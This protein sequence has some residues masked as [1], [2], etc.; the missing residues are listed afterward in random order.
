MKF[1][2]NEKIS[3]QIYL[4]ER[5]SSSLQG[6]IPSEFVI[7][8]KNS[9]HL[10]WAMCL[11]SPSFNE[12]CF[13]AEA[14][15]NLVLKRTLVINMDLFIWKII[16]CIYVLYLEVS[17]DIWTF[18]CNEIGLVQLKN[19][20][21]VCRCSPWPRCGVTVLHLLYALCHAQCASVSTSLA[22][23]SVP[24]GAASHVSSPKR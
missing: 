8:W 15:V 2:W 4:I 9:G 12:K 14:V 5:L 6:I 21:S 19:L 11:S 22:W 13:Y 24:P 18:E 10:S 20:S 7:S 23:R 16:L 1:F 3:K 17:N